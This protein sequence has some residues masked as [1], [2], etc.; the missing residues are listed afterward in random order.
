MK[1]CCCV[2]APDAALLLSRLTQKSGQLRPISIRLALGQ[3]SHLMRPVTKQTDPPSSSGV[4]IKDSGEVFHVH[5]PSR[6]LLR[7]PLTQYWH[8]SGGRRGVQRV[9]PY[10][11]WDPSVRHRASPAPWGDNG[12]LF[13]GLVAVVTRA[14]TGF[15]VTD[16]LRQLMTRFTSHVN[17]LKLNPAL[18]L[19]WLC[20]SLK[21][22]LFALKYPYF[23]LYILHPWLITH[24]CVVGH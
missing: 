9:P 18:L 16:N 6:S 17:I 4:F 11:C 7:P 24:A 12:T 2:A 1:S 21:H 20:L 15:E 3:W 19:K 10:Y 5:F 8:W 23:P 22:F 13:N 14:E